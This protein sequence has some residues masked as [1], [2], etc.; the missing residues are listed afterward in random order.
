MLF[1]ETALR[2]ARG[3]FIDHYHFERNTKTKETTCYFVPRQIH[4]RQ[5][6]QQ[7]D[8]SSVSEA[9]SNTTAAPHKYFDCTARLRQLYGANYGGSGQNWIAEDLPT[10]HGQPSCGG[11]RRAVQTYAVFG[12]IAA[13]SAVAALSWSSSLK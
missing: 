10:V 7:S 2:R 12:R 5:P 1:G 13:P 9:S 11:A 6:Q 3:E 8:A 4:K